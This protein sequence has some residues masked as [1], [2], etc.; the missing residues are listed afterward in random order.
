MTTDL[1]I[2]DNEDIRNK[3]YNIRGQNVM[4]DSD[5]AKIYG[6]TTKRFNE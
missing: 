2:I 6:Y 3:I 5:L 1:I 4:I